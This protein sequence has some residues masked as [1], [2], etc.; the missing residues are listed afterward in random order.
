MSERRTIN[1]FEWLR[2]F[3]AAA[4][5][6]IH[7]IFGISDNATVIEVG[8]A[9]AIWWGILQVA[10]RWAVPVFLMITGALLL[11]PEKHLGWEKIKQYSFRMAGVLL[12]FGFVYCLMELVFTSREINIGI[13][14]NAV[15]NLLQGRSWSHM[16]YVYA[17]LGLYLLLPVFRAYVAGA[18][19]RDMQITLSILAIFT[20]IVPTVNNV[21]G[22]GLSNLVWLTSSSFYLLLG[23]Y[24]YTYLNLTAV[25]G[26]GR[27]RLRVCR[28]RTQ[29]HGGV[30]V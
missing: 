9:R 14:Y 15:I 3:A 11:N 27:V 20:L 24:A 19:R 8:Q 23:W 6:M 18:S 30:D 2:V 10:V 13:V 5:V 17:L 1:E 29:V 12:T 21:F 16:W 28:N 4:V 25:G 26:G 22:V 7:V